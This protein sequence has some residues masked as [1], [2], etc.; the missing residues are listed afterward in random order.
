MSRDPLDSFRELLN[1]TTASTDEAPDSESDYYPGSKRKRRAVSGSKDPWDHVPHVDLLVRGS[2]HRF[3]TVGV[4]AAALDRKPPS[5]RKWE[6]LGYLP[7]SGFRSPSKSVK[8]QRRLY[9]KEQIEGVVR[10]ATEE[11]LM[12]ETN[13]NIAGTAFPA[14]CAKLFK[15]LKKK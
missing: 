10:I 4:L 12:G 14:R 2:P 6:R 9:T 15:E 13:P 3:Y 5:M 7:D 1:P 8:G 11:G